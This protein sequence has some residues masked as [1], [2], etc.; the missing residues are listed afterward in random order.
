MSARWR[1]VLL[2]VAAG[3]LA[4]GMGGVSWAAPLE[5]QDVPEPLRPWIEWALRGDPAEK[6]VT[7][8]ASFDSFDKRR[9]VWPGTLE[10][11]LGKEGGTF[12]QDWE[13]FDTAW[14]PLPFAEGVWP[15]DVKLD[16]HPA[17]FLMQD[18]APSV[19]LEAG[20][21]R[22]EGRL[23][24]KNLP[25][26]LLIRSGALVDFTLD[27]VKRE[28]IPDREGR[29]YVLGR[30]TPETAAENR[31]QLRVFRKLDDDIP[32]LLLT[33]LELEVGGAAR[34]LVA[35]KVLPPGFV[36]AEVSGPLPVRMENGTR[37]HIQAR[38]GRWVVELTARRE[39]VPLD[40]LSGWFPE[41]SFWPEEEIWSF[42]ARPQLRQASPEGVPAIDPRQQGVPSSWQK[43]PA[44]VMRKD[45]R[46]VLAEKRRG[47]PVPAPDQLSLQ[48]ELWIDFD[49]GG[50]TARD[51]ISGVM[52]RAWRLD[53][54][55]PAQLGRAAL[56]GVDQVVTSRDGRF[57]VELR[58]GKINL[59]ADSRL[60][61]SLAH[62]SASGW[63]Q[64]FVSARATLNLP[65][66]WRL[67]GATGVDS[68]NGSWLTQWTLQDMF[69][70]L[71]VALAV[72]RLWGFFWGLAALA[73][74]ALSWHEPNAPRWI[75]LHLLAAVALV[76]V[77][78]ASG[79]R[80]LAGLYRNGALVAL[81]VLLLPFGQA[82]LRF[83]LYPQLE[84]GCQVSYHTP[85]SVSSPEPERAARN[86]VVRARRP[87]AAAA[88][89]SVAAPEDGVAAYAVEEVKEMSS[90]PLK[91][92]SASAKGSVDMRLVDP[93][94]V[95]QTGP[96]VPQWQWRSC[97]L[98]WNGPLKAQQQIGL[99]LV[100]PAVNS[101]LAVMR[102]LL[103]GLLAWLMLDAKKWRRFRPRTGWLPLIPLVLALTL[104]G[105]SAVRAEIPDAELLEE[106]KSRLQ[107]PPDCFP[108]CAE[109]HAMKISCTSSHLLLE[110][111]VHAAAE[112][113]A[114]LPGGDVWLPEQVRLDGQPAP[115][116]R[117]DQLW[118]ALAPGRHQVVLEGA[119]PAHE[120][121]AL[122]LP[123]PPRQ[124]VFDG[125][126]WALDGLN[127]ERF[128]GG[129]VQLRRLDAPAAAEN[130]GEKAEMLISPFF[131][132]ERT[133]TLGLRWTVH[134][135]VT[136]RFAGVGPALLK[137]PLLPGET[138]V[139]AGLAVEDGAVTLDFPAT[140]K[141]RSW[142]STLDVAP[143]LELVAAASEN[144]R[145]TWK[146][147]VG[148]MWHVQAE[149]LAVVR[150]QDAS[151]RRLPEWRPLPGER[152]RLDIS[153]PEGVVGH[154]LTLES[155]FMTM[156][157]GARATAAVLELVWRSAKGG[158]HVLTLP[159]GVA[160]ERI[161]VDGRNQPVRQEGRQVTLALTP[162][163]QTMKLFWHMPEGVKTRLTTPAVDVGVESV[164]AHLKLK[165]PRSRW[166]VLAGGP[167]LGPAVLFWGW[168][169]LLLPLALLLGH[170][171]KT[172][173]SSV[174]WFVLGLG[175]SQLDKV[176]ALLIVCW[177]LALAARQRVTLKGYDWLFNLM[178]VGLAVLSAA[179]LAFLVVSVGQS[180]LG[181]PQM[182]I[183]G[184]GSYGS[185]LNWYQDR[186]GQQL[187]QAWV[188][189]VPL[190]IYRV[191][192]LCWALWLASMLLK[193]LRW[194]WKAFSTGGLWRAHS[195]KFKFFSRK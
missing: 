128:P 57:G 148:P 187:P 89:D 193:W 154:G 9:C 19:R 82:Q 134:T 7:C 177:L 179:A 176:G 77:L 126:G 38:P 172:P 157:P 156:E 137:V 22:L 49:G 175:L 28:A 135:V 91:A 1:K 45:A 35:D 151:G 68:E 16:G 78:P 21:H 195:L 69:I 159:E 125:E 25:E 40:A 4:L 72:G 42:E 114:P 142:E 121:L 14:V 37:T 123:L 29:L 53:M 84:P 170:L 8:P 79:F 2:M 87:M 98:R 71:L 138:V 74:L 115:V 88:R 147:E 194:G 12:A 47:D 184:N 39:G 76:R 133:I 46:L 168:L 92:V 18:G 73:A 153:R 62:L 56:D 10:L 167:R 61:G 64:D 101:A 171:K 48:R 182:G 59:Q 33:R 75:W 54:V 190:W 34:E 145:E 181:D 131:Q 3:M 183:S 112:V 26:T 189:S 166:L 113:F 129:Q 85:E 11:R 122:S 32:T 60:E 191:L 83:A 94:A 51:L 188:L 95:A 106:L 13:L 27:G 36:L 132:V 146:L 173:L 111:D 109:I 140:G 155:S 127:P 120:T 55:K 90:A 150:H 30:K 52:S 67:L 116:V 110:L 97:T 161:L 15:E 180:L 117:D 103:L 99:F 149:G 5:R 164:N 143:Q 144:F 107:A 81:L 186:A 160:L 17:L 65:P 192:M 86:R 20:H 96:G 174:H 70:V 6:P 43:L 31:L 119:L 100:S 41:S 108:R 24:W 141:S 93:D 158:D 104:S 163:L 130:D 185:L 139:S 63:E 23:A 165:M 169:A 124:I 105:V 66:G 50:L 162:G 136:R 58:Q 102:V 44:F 152:V 80:T 118:I 178:Q